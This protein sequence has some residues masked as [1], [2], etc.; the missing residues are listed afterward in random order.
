M[1]AILPCT[2][3]ARAATQ[4]ADG[5]AVRAARYHRAVQTSKPESRAPRG[6]LLERGALTRA[7]RD[8]TRRALAC[9]ALEPIR[10]DQEEIDD[11]GVRFQVRILADRDRKREARSAQPAHGAGSNPF[12]PYDA[13]LFVADV[14]PTHLC[15]LNKYPA[16]ADHLLL[17]TRSFEEQTALLTPR[18]FDALW[19]CTEEID[20]FAFYNA[21]SLAG[22]SQ[23]HRHLQ[24]VPALVPA[25]SGYAPIDALLRDARFDERIG[26]VEG[27]PFL[28]AFARLRACA[29]QPPGVAAEILH[30]LYLEMLRAFGCERG[31]PPYNLLLTREWMLLVPRSREAW[32]SISVNAL[33]FAGALLVRDRAQLARLRELGP[34]QLLRRV[35]IARD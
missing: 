3:D 17:V 33:G 12:L 34:M 10:T 6:L 8:R 13:A 26:Q 18:D 16:L 5:P 2:A 19:A 27:L 23:R 28:H 32:E 21:G 20:G 25:A 22:A 14:S 15:L 11:A 4:R 29:A 35:G 9:G 30:A 7:L 1:A 24:L 31:D